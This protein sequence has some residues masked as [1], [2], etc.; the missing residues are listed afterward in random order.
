MTSRIVTP[1]F[2]ARDEEMARRTVGEIH[3][4][5]GHILQND[6]RF[7]TSVACRQLQKGE[8]QIKSAFNKNRIQKCFDVEEEL[9]PIARDIWAKEEY[10]AGEKLLVHAFSSFRCNNRLTDYGNKHFSCSLISKTQ[11]H[12]FAGQKTGFIIRPNDG[13]IVG[14]ETDVCTREYWSGLDNRD[15]GCVYIDDE[16]CIR[17]HWPASKLKT[18]S[19]LAASSRDYYNE[20]V[21]DCAKATKL[22][23]F[24]ADGAE[25]CDADFAHEVAQ[26]M[27]L[28]IVEL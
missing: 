4:D 13:F 22:S 2:D 27:N 8:K 11:P 26:K 20:V 25:N 1:K 23:V 3:S 21:L 12:M 14:A 18:P 24:I 10:K 16:R 5:I 19:K 17:V 15:W 9:A 6:K 28:P 7:L